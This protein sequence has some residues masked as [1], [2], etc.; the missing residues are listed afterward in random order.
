[1]AEAVA[2]PAA[3]TP[4]T[5]YGATELKAVYQKYRWIAL[6]IAIGIHF[7]LIGS[8]YAVELLTQED[9]PM[10]QVRIMKYSDLG[11]PPSITS[12]NTPP[13]VAVE[14]PVAKP[15]VGTPVP[16]PDAEVSPEQT[17]ASQTEMSQQVAPVGD[18]SGSGDVAV[19][20][21]IKIDDDAP[22][23][24]YTPVEK[25]PNIIKR[26]EPKYPELAMRAGLEGKVYVKIWVDKEGKPKKVVVLKSDAEI[27]E[28]PA[29]E[30]AQ[31][32]LFTPAYM[33]NGPV[34]VWVSVPFKFRLTD[35]K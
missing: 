32:F 7:L 31:Q 25:E 35:K 16:V 2:I 9:A 14:A 23:A 19:Q 13:P 34:A 22:P 10:V 18:A 1:M 24:D 11:P 12:A 6:A 33:N 30:A 26:V 17:I 27:F 28:A 3:T 15:T 5:K 4:A 21:D 29:V 8:Y 20:Q